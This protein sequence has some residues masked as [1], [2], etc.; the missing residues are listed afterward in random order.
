[1]KEKLRLRKLC[2][3]TMFGQEL[4]KLTVLDTVFTIG[5][6]FVGDFMR[7]FLLRVLNPCWFWDLEKRFPK[8]PDFKVAENILHLVNN[9]GMIWMGLFMAP[10]LPAI[11]LVKLAIIMYVRSWAVMTTNVPHETVFRASRSNNFYF[12]LLLM[13]LFL[14]TLPVAYTVVW[15]KPS[16]HCGPFSDYNP[17]YKV[18]TEKLMR[19]LPRQL[20]GLLD[21]VTSPGIVI[22]V[23]V[24]LFLVINYLI[25]QT[26]LL[27]ESN[28]DLKEQL[29]RERTEE[30]RKLMQNKQG[31]G[32]A[33][34]GQLSDRW[35]KLLGSAMSSARESQDYRRV[36]EA[37]TPG[38][39]TG[40]TYSERAVDVPAVF[41]RP[42]PP[43][44]TQAER[45]AAAAST[46]AGVLRSRLARKRAA[47]AA[48][49]GKGAKT[50]EES[51]GKRG[52][53]GKNNK[54]HRLSG[55]SLP[56]PS[57]RGSMCN[58]FAM[59]DTESSSLSV[60]QLEDD[61]EVFVSAGPGTVSENGGDA[62]GQQG[63]N[64][65]KIWIS[66]SASMEH[67]DLD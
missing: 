17:M 65:P 4:V 22:P 44:R 63:E 66:R 26:G 16:W 12:I 47:A 61:N 33:A 35:K 9:Q 18:F 53:N 25:S 57:E 31:G 59:G 48:A 32:G 64:A 23:L 51:K 62:A 20:H 38:G 11:N 30:R 50:E 52:G 13:M 46:L 29:H 49:A 1:M 45:E 37:A 6:T 21:Y 42:P 7:A 24:L 39:E 40:T 55:G 54:G 8:Y 67:D 28:E 27:R 34:A 2:W 58:K 41:A 3:E 60:E 14:C 56:G 10:G 43:K 19:L 36:S 15:L 5:T